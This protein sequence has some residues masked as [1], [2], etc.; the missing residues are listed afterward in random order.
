[1]QKLTKEKLEDLQLQ[2]NAIEGEMEEDVRQLKKWRQNVED[3][4]RAIVERSLK[5]MRRQANTFEME[6]VAF[7]GKWAE[8]LRNEILDI[9]DYELYDLAQDLR[10]LEYLLQDAVALHEKMLAELEEV[11]E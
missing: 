5:E 6:V 11:T 1:M 10:H 8:Q 2:I 4:L 9:V 7:V 3:G